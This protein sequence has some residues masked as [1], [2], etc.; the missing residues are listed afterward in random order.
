LTEEKLHELDA[1]GWEL[2][3]LEKDYSETADLAAKSRDKLIEMIAL[4]YSEA[5]IQSFSARQPRQ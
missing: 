1:K 3:N 2:Y 4:W 5:Q